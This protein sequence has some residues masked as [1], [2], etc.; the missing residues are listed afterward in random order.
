MLKVVN[1]LIH[2]GNYAMEAYAILD[3]GSERTI[4]LAPVAQHLKLTATQKHCPY[5]QYTRMMSSLQDPQSPLKNH[6]RANLLRDTGSLMLSQL[7]GSTWLISLILFLFYNR[8]TI[9]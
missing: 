5:R 1:V 2:N 3:D 9:T 6:R 4:I 7:M 8:S